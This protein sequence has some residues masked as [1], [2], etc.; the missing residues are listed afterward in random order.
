[1]SETEEQQ[2]NLKETKDIS[3]LRPEIQEQLRD[4]YDR[5]QAEAEDPA[6]VTSRT[7]DEMGFFEG[8]WKT[9]EPWRKEKVNLG[10]KNFKAK[11][12]LVLSLIPVLGEGKALLG[13][14]HHMKDGQLVI[15]KFE[16]AYRIGRAA[17]RGGIV[18]N[19]SVKAAKLAE[20]SVFLA[21]T[22]GVFKGAW[23]AKRTM[24]M[25]AARDAQLS[26]K[27]L[28]ES[29]EL[30]A[31]KQAVVKAAELK[32]KETKAAELAKL[33]YT[34]R[35]GWLDFKGKFALLKAKSAAKKAMKVEMKTGSAAQ[36]VSKFVADK[37]KSQG[38]VAQWVESKAVHAKSA[39][40]VGVKKKKF[41]IMF[42]NLFN[43]T[44]D[45][46]LWL[47]LSTAVAEGVG[48][49]GADAIPAVLQLGKNAMHDA[50]ITMQM[51]KDVLA[52]TTNRLFGK[53]EV[54]KQAAEKFAVRPMPA[55]T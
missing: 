27:I 39:I 20:K 22:K 16:P 21:G 51:N 18:F 42:D 34:D 29:N 53:R 2:H 13:L 45:V 47:A 49:H 6:A 10:W 33:G 19:E 30:F 14:A 12:S 23:E 11:T 31:K 55:A 4:T 44:P 46:P 43:L 3:S 38:K 32:Y 24:G 28:S 35:I 50:K 25:L 54:A 15:T 40:D 7:I 26:A 17:R 37:V 36:E 48:M 5:V 8:L 1:M 9:T 41:M 52:Y